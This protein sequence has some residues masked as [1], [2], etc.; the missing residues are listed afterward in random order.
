MLAN[1]LY[2][3]AWRFC[4]AV[5]LKRSMSFCISHM[6]TPDVDGTSGEEPWVVKVTS[7]EKLAIDPAHTDTDKLTPLVTV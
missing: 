1:S 5:G 2:P 3:F 4:D 6:H 7:S